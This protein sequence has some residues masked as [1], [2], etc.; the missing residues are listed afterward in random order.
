MASPLLTCLVSGVNFG[1][2]FGNWANK[3][4]AEKL[5]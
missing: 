5:L 3:M 4:V 1:Q 2:K